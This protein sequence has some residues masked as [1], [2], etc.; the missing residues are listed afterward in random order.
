MFKLNLKQNS[1][2]GFTLMELLIVMAIGIILFAIS[3]N[4]FANLKN[5]ESLDSVSALVVEVLRQAKHATI[6]SKNSNQYG[7]YFNTNNVVLFIGPTYIAGSPTNEV[8]NFNSSVRL[9]STSINGGGNA[10]LFDRI[11]GDTVNNGTI[12]LR[13]DVS[14]TTKT[15]TIY[16]T[17][18]IEQ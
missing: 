11:T 15:I 3:I 4:T 14:S 10:V 5:K 16:K 12:V 2:N 17:G 1:K 9:Y 18:L 13:S 7:V 6:E 8:Y